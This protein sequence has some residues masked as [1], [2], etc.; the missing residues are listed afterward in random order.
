MNHIPTRYWV[1]GDAAV[2]KLLV[3]IARKHLDF[4]R[5]L[6][7]SNKFSKYLNKTPP[8]TPL[9]LEDGTTIAFNVNHGVTNV[10][11]NVPSK[12]SKKLPKTLFFNECFCNTN[13]AICKV[14]S[15]VD[16]SKGTEEGYTGDNVRYTLEVCNKHHMPCVNGCDYFLYENMM[17]T[18]FTDLIPD[19]E[20]VGSETDFND[21]GLVL[22]FTFDTENMGEKPVAPTKHACGP[23]PNDITKNDIPYYKV[24][25]F[26][27]PVINPALGIEVDLKQEW[28]KEHEACED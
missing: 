13:F 20:C 17:I 27:P 24:I 5:K 16:H 14:I 6:V 11:I 3:P 21:F 19:A 12:E 4:E 26:V 1:K 15:R 8:I 23:G 10:Y 22:L 28:I 9:R 25:P 7:A 18:D 2:G